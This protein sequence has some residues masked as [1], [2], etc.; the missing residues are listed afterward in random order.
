MSVKKKVTVPVGGLLTRSALLISRPHYSIVMD[1]SELEGIEFVRGL[2]RSAEVSLGREL[3]GV[4][5][6]AG[7]KVR[8]DQPPDPGVAGDPACIRRGGAAVG[9]RPPGVKCLTP[10]MENA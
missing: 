6:V 9:L 3:R 7:T 2:Y 10:R 5:E 8:E 1:L 4:H